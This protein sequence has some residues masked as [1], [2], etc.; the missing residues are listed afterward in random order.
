M[1]DYLCIPGRLEVYSLAWSSSSS[2]LVLVLV[3]VLVLDS[4]D[5]RA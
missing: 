5:F 4:V 2:S 1:S 3:L